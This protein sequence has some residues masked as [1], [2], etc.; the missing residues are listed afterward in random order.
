ME[1]SGSH[2]KPTT[3]CVC[4]RK[5]LSGAIGSHWESLGVVGVTFPTK[6]PGKRSNATTTLGPNQFQ[7]FKVDPISPFS[8]QSIG[9]GLVHWDS[10]LLNLELR[11]ELEGSRLGA[12]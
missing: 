3:A 9:R 8:F 7:N 10:N 5:E 1:V 12:L 2:W 11:D 6:V 4:S